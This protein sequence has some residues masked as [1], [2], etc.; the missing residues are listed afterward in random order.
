MYKYLVIAA[1]VVVAWLALRVEKKPVRDDAGRATVSAPNAPAN[2]NA[3]AVDL[4]AA[5]FEQAVAKG[6]YVVDFWADWCGPCR[7]QGPIVEQFAKSR[8][9]SVGV[10]KIDVDSEGELAQ[11]FGITGIPTLI[12]FKN[13]KEEARFVGV[14]SQEKL[15]QAVDALL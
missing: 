13:G 5:T 15:A 3:K 12:V 11:R 2:A 14:T 4:G 7:T 1:C 9:G 6:V 10:G 8:G